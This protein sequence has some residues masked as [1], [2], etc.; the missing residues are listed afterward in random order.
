MVDK[1]AG[2]GNYEELDV[3]MNEVVNKALSIQDAVCHKVWVDTIHSLHI[4]NTTP[5]NLEQWNPQLSN[6]ST[7]KITIQKNKMKERK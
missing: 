2:Y 6:L 1:Q 7:T 5:Q 3:H 4:H